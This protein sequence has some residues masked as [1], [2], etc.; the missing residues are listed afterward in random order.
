[1]VLKA[2]EKSMKRILTNDFGLSRCVY[3]LCEKVSVAS[4]ANHFGL[5]AN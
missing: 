3:A 1:M 2:E 5:Y 4:S